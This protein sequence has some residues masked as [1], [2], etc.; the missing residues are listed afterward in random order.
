MIFKIFITFQTLKTSF[1][2]H[3]RSL[4]TFHNQDLYIPELFHDLTIFVLQ[5]LECQLI[6]SYLN[7]ASDVINNMTEKGNLLLNFSAYKKILAFGEFCLYT[8]KF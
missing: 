1:K 7:L 6:Q 2:G 3:Q 8:S 5:Y 4:I